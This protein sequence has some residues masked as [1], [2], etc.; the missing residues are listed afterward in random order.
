MP[1]TEGRR[2]R[3][4]R[5][6]VS[7]DDGINAPGLKVAEKIARAVL[8]ED[9]GRPP[10]GRIILPGLADSLADEVSQSLH[11]PIEVGPICAAELPLFFGRESQLRVEQQVPT[12]ASRTGHQL[13]CAAIEWAAVGITDLEAAAAG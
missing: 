2:P 5:I 13:D 8:D 6:L 7:N 4:L 1:Q 11:R 9:T 3:R 12:Q 10:A